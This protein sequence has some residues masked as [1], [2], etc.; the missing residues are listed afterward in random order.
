ML[1]FFN[2]IRL[3]PVPGKDQILIDNLQPFRRRLEEN[4]VAE[5]VAVAYYDSRPIQNLRTNSQHAELRISATEPQL[6]QHR[7]ASADI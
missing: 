4:V 5:C 7:I 6:E 3:V 2:L 1:L